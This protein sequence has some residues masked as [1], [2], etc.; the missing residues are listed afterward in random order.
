MGTVTGGLD[1]KPTPPTFFNEEF[2]CARITPLPTTPPASA[3]NSGNE[4]S[5][6]FAFTWLFSGRGHLPRLVANSGEE[7]FA[8]LNFAAPGTMANSVG[9]EPNSKRSAASG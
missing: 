6:S 3:G 7:E 8:T 4:H 2:V 5:T 1:A 9:A